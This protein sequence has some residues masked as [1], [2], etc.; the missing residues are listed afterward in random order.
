M[1]ILVI[2]PNSTRAMT[3]GVEGVIKPLGYGVQYPRC[4]SLEGYD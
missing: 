1:A 3:E 2:N 4:L